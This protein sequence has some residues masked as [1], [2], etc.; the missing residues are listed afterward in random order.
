MFQYG[1]DRKNV[2]FVIVPLKNTFDKK[3]T[4]TSITKE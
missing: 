2:I 4:K 3:I 1:L